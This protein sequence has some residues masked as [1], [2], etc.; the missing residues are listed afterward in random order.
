VGENMIQII[1][2]RPLSHINII[3]FPGSSFY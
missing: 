1:N 2:F 3:C